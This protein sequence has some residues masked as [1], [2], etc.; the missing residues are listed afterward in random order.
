M[1]I[2]LIAGSGMAGRAAALTLRRVGWTGEIV[3]VGDDPEYPYDRPPLSKSVVIGT[4]D[5][6]KVI[7]IENMM[8]S[9]S[10]HI[11]APFT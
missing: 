9:Y 11:E 7:K 5:M 3:L 10:C 1:T 4:A 6:N 2:A 8:I